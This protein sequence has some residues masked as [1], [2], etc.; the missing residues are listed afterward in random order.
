VRL[1]KAHALFGQGVPVIVLVARQM[2]SG[3]VMA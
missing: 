3:I 2:T 1:A